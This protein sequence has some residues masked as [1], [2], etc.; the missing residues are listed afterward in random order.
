M[1]SHY[2]RERHKKPW[3]RSRHV[4]YGPDDLV[5]NDYDPYGQCCYPDPSAVRS[6]PTL[7]DSQPIA[8]RVSIIPSP[9]SLL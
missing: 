6:D 4:S 8:F 7:P 1:D 5:E 2:L 3:A 9:V